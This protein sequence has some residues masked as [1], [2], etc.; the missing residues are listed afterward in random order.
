MPVRVVV[1]V[2]EQLMPTLAFVLH[3]AQRWGKRLASVH[4]Y[5]TD[6]QRRSAE[7]AQRL[8]QVIVDW[9][10]ARRL[11]VTVDIT[12]GGMQPQADVPGRGMHVAALKQAA[13]D[14][15]DFFTGLVFGHGAAG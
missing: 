2:S 5:C 15:A 14:A 1:L 10:R 9:T 7:P 3:A 6:D 13:T 12:V 4:I 11:S 8:Q